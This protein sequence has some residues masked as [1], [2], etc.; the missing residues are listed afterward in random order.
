MSPASQG[1]PSRQTSHDWPGSR[2]LFGGPNNADALRKGYMGMV[3]CPGQDADGH[4]GAGWERPK[5][6]APGSAG[7]TC[8]KIAAAIVAIV[9]GASLGVSLRQIP[10]EKLQ[11]MQ[12]QLAL[13][14]PFPSTQA[15]AA[16]GSK[17]GARRHAKSTTTLP[18]DC[19]RPERKAS[20]AKQEWCCHTFG[21]GCGE[22]RSNP[23]G[24]EVAS[25][26]AWSVAEAT[27]CCHSR[28]L[29]C[30]TTR[31]SQSRLSCSDSPAH[32]WPAAKREAC[33]KAFQVGC[34]RA[35]REEYHCH[36]GDRA[37]WSEPKKAWCCER[38][39]VGC[40]VA[41]VSHQNKHLPVLVTPKIPTEHGMPG[42][43]TAPSGEHP[44]RAMMPASFR[45]GKLFTDV[46]GA[47]PL[48]VRWRQEW[49]QRG[50]KNERFDC[51]AGKMD[52][53][54]NWSPVQKAWCCKHEHFACPPVPALE[55]N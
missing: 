37:G 17:A 6:A 25:Q 1:D 3:E 49:N 32:F 21:T 47:T 38:Q 46:G 33:C 9:A 15:S 55:I 4:S 44:A 53:M 52:W 30:S 11:T 39:V 48:A 7:R 18:F 34:P 29:G 10:P 8:C 41:H 42:R 2:T 19:A 5:A 43:S 31:D 23:Y 51:N 13:M 36:D 24:C 45:E 20:R 26:T 28:G 27:W 16:E 14:L 54:A 40:Q 22:L 12:N 50:S 35:E